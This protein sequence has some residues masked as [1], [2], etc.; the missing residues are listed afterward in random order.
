MAGD[1]TEVGIGPTWDFKNEKEL[2][3]KYLAKEEGVGQNKSILYKIKKSD[4]SEIGV[5]GNTL[6][7]DKFSRISIGCEVRLVYLGMET[8]KAGKQYHSFKVYFKQENM[9]Y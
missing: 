5:W 4:G 8:S 6:L 1:W 2:T 9:P 7:D 3:G